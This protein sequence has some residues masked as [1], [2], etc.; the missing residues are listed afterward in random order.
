[1]DTTANTT[2]PDTGLACLV[3]IAGFHQLAADPAQLRHELA[4]NGLPLD[5]K[6]LR[7]GAKRLG[8]KSRHFACVDVG[9]LLTLPLPAMAMMKDGRFVVIARVT[10]KKILLHDPM[11]QRPVALSL[12][13]FLQQWNQQVIVFKPRGLLIKAQRGFSLAWFLPA[14]I[15]HRRQLGEVLLASFFLQIFALATPLFFQVVIDKVLVHGGTNTLKVLAGG[16]FL[17]ALFE[18]ALS[19]L[20][21]FLLAHT[22]NRIDVVLGARLF[23]HMLSLPASYYSARR[24]GDTVARV[25]EL[26]TI[27]QFITGSSLTVVIDLLFTVVF[28]AL[29]YVYSPQL[30]L[31]VLASIPLYILLSISVTPSIR[32]RMQQK[33]QHGAENQAF[34]VETV[35]GM[36]TLKSLAVEPQI[37]RRW[38]RQLAGYVTASFAAGNLANIASQLAGLINKL[39]TLLVLW[40][41]ASL[42]MAGALSVGQLIAFNMFASR[43]SAPILRVVQLWQEFQQAGIAL[44]RLGDILNTSAEPGLALGRSAPARLSGA[45]QFKSLSHRYGPDGRNVLQG[46]DL[47]IAAGEVIGIVGESGSGKS[48]IAKLIQRLYLPT[49]GRLLIDGVDIQQLPG[50][51]L[52]RQI[53]TVQQESFLFN[54]SVRDNIAL[55]KTGATFEQVTDAAKIAGAHEFIQQLPEGYDTIIGEQGKLISGGQKQRIAIARALI[56]GPRILILDEASS[57]LDYQ[58]EFRIQQNM[59]RICRN[60]TV[61]IIAHRLSTVRNADRIAVLDKGRI[62]E[63]GN[64]DQLVAQRGYYARL[65]TLQHPSTLACSA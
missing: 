51:F 45:I 46:I 52:R 27:R 19:C 25:R 31:V 17:L 61:I 54:L 59:Q 26:E 2:P 21:N 43:V 33:F 12:E 15:K 30:S 3:L 6:Q 41:G 47:S 11:E 48:T 29:L 56:G 58:S 9:N 4:E 28:L 65:H 44:E 18:V 53:G 13:Q 40:F 8:L 36:D 5:I 1:M 37:Q 23:Q 14:I 16:M 39:T 34:L 35:N 22:S 32:Q 50:H 55:A 20:R 7:R 38:E 62:V 24:V 64:H 10:D 60:R 49:H 63:C 42:V 57:A